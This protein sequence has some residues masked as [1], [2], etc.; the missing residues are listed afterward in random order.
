[1]D[2]VA[3]TIRIEG[4]SFPGTY[5]PYRRIINHRVVKNTYQESDIKGKH[6]TLYEANDAA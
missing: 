4:F 3:N 5:Q 1:M 2:F 6:H